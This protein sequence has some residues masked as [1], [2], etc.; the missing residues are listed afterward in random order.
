MF[1]Y[2]TYTRP[3]ASIIPKKIL[4]AF[5]HTMNVS[6]QQMKEVYATHIWAN[7][8]I[9][10]MMFGHAETHSLNERKIRGDQACYYFKK[11]DMAACAVKDDL[12]EIHKLVQ[13]SDGLIIAT[14]IYFAG[15]TSQTK[16]WINR[17]FPYIGMD[18]RPKL[19]GSKN[20]SFIFTRNQPGRQAVQTPVATFMPMVELTGL[21]V[22]DH[23]V[24][25][26]L[27]AGIK[28]PV[29]EKNEFMAKAYQIGVELLGG[30]AGLRQDSNAN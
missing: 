19:P 6:E 3:P 4:T 28:T 27:D 23:L 17:L 26:D 30:R 7:E 14:P 1:P 11:N 29:T 12:Q 5:I 9:L 22:K 16:A 20:V 2:L 13:E 25:Y 15:I 18:S 24:A 8:N 21:S 10:K